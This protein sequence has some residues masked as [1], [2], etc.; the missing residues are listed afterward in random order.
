MMEDVKKTWHHGKA[1]ATYIHTI[2]SSETFDRMETAALLELYTI[3]KREAQ[4]EIFN[5]TKQ[6]TKT[7]MITRFEMLECGNNFRG[8]IEEL[9]NIWKCIDENHGFN[10]CIRWRD[11]NLYDCNEKVDLNVIHSDSLH[12]LKPILSKI[13]TVWNIKNAYGTFDMP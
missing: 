2:A 5:S 3:Y 11:I 10:Y 13:E 7:L 4:K 12:N 6:E 9:C 8:S 1:T